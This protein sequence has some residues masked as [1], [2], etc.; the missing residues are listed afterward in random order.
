MTATGSVRRDQH[1]V[2]SLATASLTYRVFV[3]EIV[4]RGRL[5]TLGIL[6]SFIVVVG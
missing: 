5:I 2:G 3:R 6:S 1:E 4:T